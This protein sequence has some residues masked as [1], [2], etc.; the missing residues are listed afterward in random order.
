M[1]PGA[2]EE[3]VQREGKKKWEEKKMPRLTAVVGGHLGGHSLQVGQDARG[4]TVYG[5]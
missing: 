3:K 1:S 4:K 5:D 2:I